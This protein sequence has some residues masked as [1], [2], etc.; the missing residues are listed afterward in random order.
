M[1]F[2]L[3]IFLSVI[4]S[5]SESDTTNLIQSDTTQTAVID[6]SVISIVEEDFEEH[7]SLIVHENLINTFFANMGEI[8]GEGSFA[9]G[10]YSWYLLNPRIEIEPEG[11]I[12]Q[13]QIRVQGQGGNFR[14]TRDIEGTVKITYDKET[15]KF[16]LIDFGLC[17]RFQI[18]NNH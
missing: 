5:Q 16:K 2:Y 14:V 12:F 3:L 11:G 17:K 7:I 1:K 8:K 4:L 6:T 13:G 18:D 10:D 9:L 15:N